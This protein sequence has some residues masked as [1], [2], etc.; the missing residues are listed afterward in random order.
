ML[1]KQ[2]GSGIKKEIKAKH[3]LPIEIQ[4]PSLNQQ[5]EIIRQIQC[6]ADYIEEVN[7]QIQ[8]QA[9]YAE[10][11][12]QCILQQAVE[13]KLYDHDSNDEPANV[14]L[15]KINCR[16]GRLMDWR[17]RREIRNLVDGILELNTLHRPPIEMIPAIMKQQG[18]IFEE[19]DEDDE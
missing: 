8:Q 12:R 13:C 2:T 11:L 6:A 4:L 18:I 7:Q 16:R 1:S 15:E 3:L 10:M 19:R 5:H 9:K 14:L 17:R